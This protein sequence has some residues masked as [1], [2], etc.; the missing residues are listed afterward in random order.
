MGRLKLSQLSTT[1]RVHVTLFYSTA[2]IP[3]PKNKK[4]R[5]KA[6]L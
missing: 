6:S 2:M 1:K 3:N 5:I 4:D